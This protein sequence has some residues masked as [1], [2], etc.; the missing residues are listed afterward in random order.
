M[1]EISL[2]TISDD[3]GLSGLV[4][5]QTL[6]LAT[7]YGL[8]FLAALI[9]IIIGV[10][11]SRRASQVV[12]LADKIESHRQDPRPHHGRAGALCNPDADHRRDTWQF[13]R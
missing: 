7:E 6:T 3:L 5:E 11:A 10:W 8:N 1:N 12:R 4:T 13:W 9:T 2:S